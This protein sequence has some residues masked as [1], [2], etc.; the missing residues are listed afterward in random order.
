[1]DV[2][3]SSFQQRQALVGSTLQSNSVTRDRD[4]PINLLPKEENVEC[5]HREITPSMRTQLYN[6]LVLPSRLG[7][8][9]GH[10]DEAIFDD[11]LMTGWVDTVRNAMAARRATT[12]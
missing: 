8:S 1:M 5:E 7:T 6:Y 2:I 10:L 4:P 9:C 12:K 11:E 3:A